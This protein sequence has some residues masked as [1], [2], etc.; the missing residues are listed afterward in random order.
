MPGNLHQYKGKINESHPVFSK[1]PSLPVGTFCCTELAETL[2]ALSRR[3]Q[4]TGQERLV[5]TGKTLRSFN[6]N[7]PLANRDFFTAPSFFPVLCYTEII[8]KAVAF[9]FVVVAV[10]LCRPNA[11]DPQLSQTGG[12][13]DGNGKSDR[14]GKS[15]PI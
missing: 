4:P 7:I 10:V 8:Q 12:E 13:A 1:E 3:S 15:D 14:R 2:I 11:L 6:Q 5:W 9:L